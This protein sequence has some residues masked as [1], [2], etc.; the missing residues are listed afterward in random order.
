MFKV[1]GPTESQTRPDNPRKVNDVV[2]VSL[3][4]IQVPRERVTSVWTPEIE[5]EFEQSIKSKGILSP[6]SLLDIDGALWLIDGLHRL[7]M[8]ERLGLS[9]IPAIVKKG[10]LEDLLIEN[11]I[12]NRQR[13]KSNPAEEADV[14]AYLVEKRGFPLETASSQLGLSPDWSRKLLKIAR[15]PESVKD[16]IKNGKIPVTGAIYLGDLE[17]PRALESVAKDAALYEYTAYQIKARV[18]QLLNPDQEPEQ[19]D[20]TFT[21]NGK[22]QRIPIRCRYCGE[23]LPDVGKQ[24]IWICGR[25]EK[26]AAGL[27]RD[28]Y[29][30]LA[31]R[32]PGTHEFDQK[33]P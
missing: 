8:A 3:A 23:E 25:C 12:A 9:E 7:G 5:S 33:Q 28:Y 18:S 11:L 10:S 24:Y 16:L 22:P 20:V 1:E 19:G 30:A 6:V 17:D 31:E 14:L 4:S 2:M 21:P 15:L 27:L 32:T 29:Q 13:G 26:D